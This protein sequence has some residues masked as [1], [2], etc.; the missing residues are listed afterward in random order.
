MALPGDFWNDCCWQGSDSPWSGRSVYAGQTTRNESCL[1]AWRKH[2]HLHHHHRVGS[3]DVD[4]CQGGHPSCV[5][6]NGGKGV[7]KLKA[8]SFAWQAR[9]PQKLHW[10]Q[11]QRVCGSETALSLVGDKLENQ[12]AS[13]DGRKLTPSEWQFCDNKSIERAKRRQ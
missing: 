6:T 9:P 13:A 7:A 2:L 3:N 8:H 11:L 12:H 4:R 5:E 10:P 1:P